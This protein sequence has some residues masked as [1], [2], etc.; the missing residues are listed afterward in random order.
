MYLVKQIRSV[1]SCLLLLS[2]CSINAYSKP[3]PLKTNKVF[4]SQFEN[5][6]G[7][8]FEMKI[9]NVSEKQGTKAETIAL[10]E[11]DRLSK[12]LSSYDSKSEFNQFLAT[13]NTVFKASP[14]L[15]EV[16]S[17]F[18]NWKT[19]TKGALNPA[20]EVVNQVWKKA[21]KTNTLPTS[22]ELN[23]AINNAANI[24]YTIN[25]EQG[26]ITHLTNTPLAINT[27]VKSFIIE[28]AAK[29][30]MDETGIPNIVMNVGGDIAAY[31]NET[32]QVA[33]VNPKASAINDASLTEVKIKNQFIATSGNYRRGSLIEGKW[34]SHIIDPRNGQPVTQVISATVIADNATDAGALATSF[35]I[36]PVEQSIELAKQYPNT[37]YLI[38]TEEGA[39]I[40]SDNWDKYTTTVTPAVAPVIVPASSVK[41]DVWDPAYEL[42]VN[43]ELAQMQGPAR[44]PF[45]AIWVEDKDKTPL[46]TISLWYN[47]PRWLHDL[48]AWYSANYGKYNV[49]SGTINSITSATRT[50]GKYAIKWDGK[51]DK[52]EFVKTGNYTINIEVVREHGTYQIITQEVKVNNKENKIELTANTEVASASIEVKKKGNE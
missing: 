5:V 46:R 28:K 32:E 47:K 22:M 3:G 40:K 25:K 52:G 7:T 39:Q 20:V 18:D 12:I 49:E 34:Y 43:L 23:E 1:L 16:L 27:F 15:I 45:V 21:A 26:T 24:H 35:N 31:G 41:K 50:P 13:H 36:L 51:D 37:A 29:K 11:I 2:V 6:M 48:R 14:E 30:V 19:N 38:I 33:I 17:L 4:T 9:K 8:S 44:R 42:T 10:Q